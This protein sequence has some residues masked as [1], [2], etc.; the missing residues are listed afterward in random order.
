MTDDFMSLTPAQLIE[1]IEQ[2]HPAA[3][4]VLAAKLFEAGQKDEAV[5]WFYTG[6]IRYRCHL[7][8]NPDLDPSGDPALFGALSAQVGEPL[9]VYAFGDVPKLAATITRA[10]DW[11]AAH[12][13]GCTDRS[14]HAAV[15]EEVRDGLV[16]LREHIL[17]NEDEIR[18]SRKEA[19]LD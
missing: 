6:Q 17:S 3:Y 12:T 8:A 16:E 13:D 5:F 15:C 1:T 10:L 9:N 7:A 18:Q 14:A 11:D 4:Y 2:Q 19:G